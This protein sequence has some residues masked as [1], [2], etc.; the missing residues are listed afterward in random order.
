MNVSN[1][2]EPPDAAHTHPWKLSDVVMFP[3]LGLSILAEWLWPTELSTLP[4]WVRGPVAVIAISGGQALIVAAKRTLDQA[5]QPSL[6]G[7]P[8][9]ELVTGGPYRWSRN[10]NYL[11]AILM[12]LGLVAL[13]NS[14]WFLGISFLAALVLDVWMIRPEERYLDRHFG[15]ES[16]AYRARVR[17]WI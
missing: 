1:P 7:H 5:R 8:T 11:G 14:V 4:L 2:K 9:T 17:R 13:A 15:A 6:P 10:P 16:T 3:A 12:A